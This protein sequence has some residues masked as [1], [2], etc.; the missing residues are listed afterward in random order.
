MQHLATTT[1]HITSPCVTVQLQY[2]TLQNSTKLCNHKTLLHSFQCYEPYTYR[3]KHYC[4]ITLF[5]L[6]LQYK[7]ITKR[8]QTLLLLCNHYTMHYSTITIHYPTT[9]NIAV[10]NNYENQT[11]LYNYLI[12]PYSTE[13]NISTPIQHYILSTT[14][15]NHWTRHSYTPQ[16]PKTTHYSNVH[17]P[18]TTQLYFTRLL[19]YYTTHCVTLQHNHNTLRNLTSTLRYPTSPYSTL[20]SQY[21]TEL[22]LTLTLLYVTILDFSNTILH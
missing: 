15:Y 8:Y 1:Q 9:L 17:Y 14:P 2:T 19:N 16:L 20:Q 10:P 11:L 22:Y 18:H 4:S 6:V 13:L 12:R 21:K 7:S 3:T 5:Y